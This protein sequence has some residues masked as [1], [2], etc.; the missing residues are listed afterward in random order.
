VNAVVSPAGAA[1]TRF[2]DLVW[3]NWKVIAEYDGD[4]HRSDPRRYA[5]DI[6]RLEQLAAEGWTVA[7]VL[8]DHLREPQKVVERVSSALRSHGWRARPTRAHL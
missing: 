3:E 1:I 2:G 4:H 7:R 5:K 6:E 8:K